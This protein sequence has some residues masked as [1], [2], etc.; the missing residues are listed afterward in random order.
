MKTTFKLFIAVCFTLTASYA[1]GQNYGKLLKSAIKAQLGNDLKGYQVFDSPTDNFGLITTYKKNTK[2][3]NFECDMFDCI[4]VTA[5]SSLDQNWMKMNGFAATGDNG[6]TINLSQDVQKELGITAVLPK[7]FKV[8]GLSTSFTDEQISHLDLTLGKVY[9]RKLRKTPMQGYL[10]GLD[11]ESRHY[12]LFNSGQMVLI[13]ADVVIE[14]MDVE[15]TLKDTSATAIDTKFGWSGNTVA[16]KILDSAALG[17][18]ITK[19]SAGK[20]KF[21]LSHPVIFARLAAKQPKAGELGAANSD[22][23]D[24]WIVT[25]ENIEIDPTKIP[26]KSKDEYY[27]KN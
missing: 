2:D 17:I 25:D 11:K 22:N 4:G 14:S 5:P 8:V 24:E 26:S 19:Q 16:A 1:Q 21:T 12:K 13:V 6:R 23:F 15:I 20:Y 7:I 10:M 9:F 18:K 27:Q 3:A